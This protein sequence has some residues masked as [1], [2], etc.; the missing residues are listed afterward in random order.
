MSEEIRSYRDLIVWQKAMDL[1]EGVYGLAR[2]LPIEE[3]YALSDQ[4]RR[5]S[6]SIP[7]NIAEGRARQGKK[8]FSHFFSI[9]QGSIAELETQVLLAVRMKLIKDSDAQKVLDLA[10]EVSRMLMSLKNRMTV[11]NT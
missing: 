1:C 5:A 6:V 2:K 9:A 4:M 3:R 10:T 7:S 8:E 11:S